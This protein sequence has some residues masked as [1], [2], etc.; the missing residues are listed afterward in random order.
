MSTDEPPTVIEDHDLNC[1]ESIVLNDRDIKNITS[2]AH[3]LAMV[4]GTHVTYK[5]MEFA[6]KSNDKR[7]ACTHRAG[8]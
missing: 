5:H 6:A 4:E 2:V 3:V 1:L 8:T 7:K